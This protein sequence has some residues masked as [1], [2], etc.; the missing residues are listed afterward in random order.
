MNELIAGFAPILVMWALP[1]APM[2]YAAIA[3]TVE[4][5]TEPAQGRPGRRASTDTTVLKAR[6][7]VRQRADQAPGDQQAA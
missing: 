6:A 3:A 2:V 7:A 4:A 1:L 5:L